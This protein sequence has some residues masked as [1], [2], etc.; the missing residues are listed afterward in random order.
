MVAFAG[1]ACCP[2]QCDHI[3]PKH[4]PQTLQ[5][6]SAQSP[7]QL[8]VTK[9]SL[10]YYDWIPAVTS[11]N[12]TIYLSAHLLWYFCPHKKAGQYRDWCQRPTSDAAPDLHFRPSTCDQDTGFLS[13]FE[14]DLW[15]YQYFDY[16]LSG[17]AMVGGREAR[18][19]GTLSICYDPGARC[20]D[21]EEVQFCKQ[22]LFFI[23]L[24]I[25]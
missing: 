1:G 16:D 15:Y 25:A 7:L 5:H 18:S 22:L 13:G 4:C 8:S 24:T 14:Q 23:K 9:L 12:H 3:A 10:A 17:A 19:H 6:V 21:E 2:L 20:E 11:V